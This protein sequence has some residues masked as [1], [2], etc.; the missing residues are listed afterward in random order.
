VKP[1][2]R[3]TIPDVDPA[4]GEASAQGEVNA[5]LRA[6]RANEAM[7]GAITFA[8]NGIILSGTDA[9]LRVGQDVTANWNF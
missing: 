6:Y 1:C 2:A 5:V 8:M 4:T 9:T 3:C 7:G